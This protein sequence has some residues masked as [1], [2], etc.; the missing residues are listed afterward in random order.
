MCAVDDD[1]FLFIADKALG[2]MVRIDHS[3]KLWN[4]YNVYRGNEQ[5]VKYRAESVNHIEGA[6]CD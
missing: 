1:Q 4:N 2:K 6:A 3:D 5:E